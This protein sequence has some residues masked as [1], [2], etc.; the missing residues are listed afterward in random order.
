MSAPHRLRWIWLVGATLGVFTVGVASTALGAALPVIARDLALPLSQ[1]R[2]ISTGPELT[3]AVLVVP[4]AFLGRLLGPVRFYLFG[5][6]VLV[7]ASVLAA[8]ASTSPV[9]E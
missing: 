6:L 7:L 5:A 9:L 4:A 2:W 3:F 1:L 8:T